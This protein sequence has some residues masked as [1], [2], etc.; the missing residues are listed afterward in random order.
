MALVT[1]KEYYKLAY[2]PGDWRD[3]LTT[4]QLR[5]EVKQV[6]DKQR[7]GMFMAPFESTAAALA[8]ILNKADAF[9]SQLLEE[10]QGFF[11]RM[12]KA[13]GEVTEL[14]ASLKAANEIITALREENATLQSKVERPVGQSV[15]AVPAQ[16]PGSKPAG[17]KPAAKGNKPVVGNKR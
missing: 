4:N 17:T 6:M 2:N 10:R 13:E 16:R 5:L 15:S 9:F 8:L 7:L 12:V 14:H 1:N 3:G 11:A